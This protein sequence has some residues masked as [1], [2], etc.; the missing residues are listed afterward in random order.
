MSCRRCIFWVAGAVLTA[1]PLLPF[2]WA[3]T[4]PSTREDGTSFAQTAPLPP[5][6][7]D[8]EAVAEEPP[9]DSS[10]AAA[11]APPA[12]DAA[13]SPPETSC[14]DRLS[15]MSVRYDER[16]PL[17]EGLCGAKDLVL[18][19]ALPGEVAVTPP[20][21][22]ACPVAEALARWSVDHVVPA[23]QRTLGTAPKSILIGTSYQ[24]RD[25]RT[26]AK[27]SEHAFA[28][29]VD[30]TGFTF[31]ERPPLR[32]APQAGESPEAAFQDAIRKA[33]CAA[34]TTVLGPGA[35]SNHDDHLHLDLRER[36][37]DYRICQ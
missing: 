20:A 18:V 5:P 6:R 35:D 32:I 1:G 21:L 3:E 36:K 23:S 4:V 15:Q 9:E 26:G 10:R 7:P 24:C 31:S 19:S 34:F 12:P 14:P 25:Q 30:V 27:L 22:M 2:A 16:P 33:A 11:T 17:E 28:N 8:R 13:S 37:G 29:A